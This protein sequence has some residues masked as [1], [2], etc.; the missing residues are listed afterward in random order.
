MNSRLYERLAGEEHILDD[1]IVSLPGRL[2]FFT[3]SSKQEEAISNAAKEKVL[4][5]Y[6]VSLLDLFAQKERLIHNLL[7]LIDS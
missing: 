7:Y 6:Q 2:L 5:S 3:E 4:F 1:S